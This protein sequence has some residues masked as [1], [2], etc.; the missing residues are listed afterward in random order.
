MKNPEP[1]KSLTPS[2]FQ[3]AANID[4]S[5]ALSQIKPLASYFPSGDQV[6]SRDRLERALQARISEIR[7]HVRMDR[8][9]KP[10]RKAVAHPFEMADTAKAA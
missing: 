7:K 8:Q 5:H 9:L 2:L 3:I 1:A 4:D 10:A 6:F